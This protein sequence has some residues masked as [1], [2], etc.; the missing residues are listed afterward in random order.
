MNPSLAAVADEQSSV[1][2]VFDAG[3]GVYREVSVR[4]LQFKD[5]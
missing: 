3:P 5:S 1:K 4:A 2:A